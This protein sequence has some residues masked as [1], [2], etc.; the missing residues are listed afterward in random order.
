MAEAA[1]VAATAPMLSSADYV[2]MVEREYLFDPAN[3]NHQR[4][5]GIIRKA[6]RIGEEYGGA[7]G[8]WIMHQEVVS[9]LLPAPNAMYAH[10]VMLNFQKLMVMCQLRP[11]TLNVDNAVEMAHDMAWWVAVYT[12]CN[13]GLWLP[14]LKALLSFSSGSHNAFGTAI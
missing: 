3:P 14:P 12:Q 8:A 13:N 5:L 1:P 9:L 4:L 10:P 2:A 6:L 11:G 7:W